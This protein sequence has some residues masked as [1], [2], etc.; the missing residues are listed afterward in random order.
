MSQALQFL[1][2]LFVKHAKSRNKGVRYK[3]LKAF[4]RKD[5]GLM[6]RMDLRRFRA[7]AQSQDTATGEDDVVKG[8]VKNAL[9]RE[10]ND[11]SSVPCINSKVPMPDF[12]PFYCAGR[13]PSVCSCGMRL[14]RRL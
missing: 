2:E 13:F 12:T 11:E 7:I 1:G 9:A 8:L 10:S 14:G 5:A 4:I 6:L 3:D